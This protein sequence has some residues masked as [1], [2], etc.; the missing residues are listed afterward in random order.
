[1]TSRALWICATLLA[2][3]AL[4]APVAAQDTCEV[5]GLV[6]DGQGNPVPD[7]KVKFTPVAGGSTSYE[8]KTNK[9]GRYFVAGMFNPSND[10]MWHV[11]IS[12]E[13]WAAVGMEVE[14]R[15][16][17]RV[18][19]GDV[20]KVAL[21]AGAQIPD[22]MVR[23][24]GTA[25]VDFKL[26]TAAEV[27]AA[28]AAEAAA[29]SGGQQAAATPQVDPWEAALSRV[30]AGDLQGSIEHFEK[31]IAD[32][33]EEAERRESLAK[34]YYRLERYDEAEKRALEAIEL[35]PQST[36]PRMVL[37]S[38]Y[39][40]RGDMDRAQAVVREARALAPDDP[41]ILRQV[42]YVASEAGDSAAA[43][44]AYESLVQV[45]EKDSDA[46]LALA[47]LYAKKGDM[48]KSEQA[49]QK[50]VEL[51]PREAPQVFYN[52]GALIMNKDDRGDED[53]QRAIDAFRKAVE[54]KPDYREAHKQL[55]FALLGTGDT[56]GAKAELEACLRIAPDAPDSKQVKALIDS[57]K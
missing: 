46:W 45:H 1:M 12:G 13:G 16:A 30:S 39:V 34:V 44:E 49:Y 23:P 4:A 35:A 32:K 48:G 54:L 47:G 36:S 55:A 28:S 18:L 29:A 2:L 57:L 43:I 6:V 52:L 15:N 3:L 20:R 51:N 53:T 5:S 24:L 26:A 21:K 25:R 37:Y 33:P 56:A 27:A 50:V 17:Q 42:A 8:G 41:N 22:I 14:S 9:K 38:V 31:A 7:V 19:M 11:E 40:G 10:G